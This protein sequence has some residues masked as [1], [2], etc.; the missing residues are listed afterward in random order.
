VT[1]SLRTSDPGSFTTSQPTWPRPSHRPD[2]A[3]TGSLA[4]A[5]R[6]WPG[7]SIGAITMPPPASVTR[8]AVTSQ[9]AV[10][11]YTFHQNAVAAGS[12][13]WARAATR[14]P[15]SRHWVECIVSGGPTWNSQANRAP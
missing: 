1:R 13:C 5:M 9:S 11:R 12:G 6:P 8:L 3:P 14:R 15:P 7:M 4:M 10:A 2:W